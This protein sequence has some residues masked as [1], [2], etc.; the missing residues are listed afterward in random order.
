MVC[1]LL[2]GYVY[3]CRICK[4]SR[5]TNGYCS[6]DSAST[7]PWA[8]YARSIPINCSSGGLHEGAQRECE[9]ITIKRGRKSRDPILPRAKQPTKKTNCTNHDYRRTRFQPGIAHLA[10]HAAEMNPAPL[11]G[12]HGGL[13]WSEAGLVPGLRIDNV[14]SVGAAEVLTE[15]KRDRKRAGKRVAVNTS[16]GKMVTGKAIARRW[17]L[18]KTGTSVCGNCRVK[19]RKEEGS[20]YA[21]LYGKN[22]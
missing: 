13:F 2:C 17:R 14:G 8:E 10:N 7:S 18:T 21:L 4:S 20:R 5:Y 16:D 3:D 1:G 15:Q 12:K 22:K 11:L 19:Q 6:R 9:P